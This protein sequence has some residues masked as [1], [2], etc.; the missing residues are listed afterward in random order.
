MDTS[1]MQTQIKTWV[2]TRLGQKAMHPHERGSRCEEET[3]EL[4]Q[5]VGGTR[6]E[7]HRIVDHVFDKAAGNPLQELGGCALTLLACAEALDW[8]LGLAAQDELDRVFSLPMEKFQ[9]RQAQNVRDG[10]GE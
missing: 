10:I 1:D 6:E 2:V 4:F 8:D 9:K 7:A 3:T 5:A